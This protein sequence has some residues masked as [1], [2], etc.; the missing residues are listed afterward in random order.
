MCELRLA[1]SE[2]AIHLVDA[3]G[4]EATIEDSV[5]LLAA[6][7]YAEAGLAEVEDFGTGGEASSVGLGSVSGF[8]VGESWLA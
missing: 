7:R 2:L 4:L 6:G 5:P 1:T 3:P 8:K